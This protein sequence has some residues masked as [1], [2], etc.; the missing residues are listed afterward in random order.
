MFIGL[1]WVQGS[2]VQGSRFR[3]QGS[4]FRVLAG[5]W[6]REAESCPEHRVPDYRFAHDEPFGERDPG[7]RAKLGIAAFDEL[8]EV[9]GGQTRADGIR[10]GGRELAAVA[11]QRAPLGLV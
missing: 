6:Q 10:G 4:G 9:R 3:V 5:S 2:W 8:I 1:L 7:E 11:R